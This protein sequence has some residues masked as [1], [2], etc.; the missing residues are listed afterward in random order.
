[1]DKRKLANIL[2]ES[3]ESEVKEKGLVRKRDKTSLY[4]D[5]ELMLEFKQRCEKHNRAMSQV[6]E[7]LIR[8]Y[9]GKPDQS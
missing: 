5:K 9:L 3:V 1:M 8:R 6:L 2:Q 4:L 7:T